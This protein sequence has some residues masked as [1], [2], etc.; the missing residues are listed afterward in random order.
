MG[1]PSLGHTQKDCVVV[2]DKRY[3]LLPPPPPFP[4]T[5]GCR[6][7]SERSKAVYLNSAG[8]LQNRADHPNGA[9]HI[10]KHFTKK[11]NLLTQTRPGEANDRFLFHTTS[12]SV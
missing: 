6:F 8:E 5:L 2:T 9:Y 10:I 1:T 12:I 3:N 11:W 7:L 4:P